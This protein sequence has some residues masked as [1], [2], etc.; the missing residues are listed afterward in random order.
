MNLAGDGSFKLA[1]GM[2][3]FVAQGMH[4]YHP[5][6]TTSFGVSRLA[7][8]LKELLMAQ[9]KLLAGNGMHL[10]VQS[11]W[12]CYVLSNVVSLDDLANPATMREGADE[13]GTEDAV[14]TQC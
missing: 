7:P 4:I 13:F 1:T 5:Q 3:H 12:M 9:Q 2:E 8:F 11:S 14:D 10:K 6:Q